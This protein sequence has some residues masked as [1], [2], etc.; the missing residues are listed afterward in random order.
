MPTFLGKKMGQINYGAKLENILNAHCTPHCLSKI[1]SI[2]IEFGTLL[3]GQGLY[4]CI[5]NFFKIVQ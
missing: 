4:N 2:T 1:N 5:C 3:F